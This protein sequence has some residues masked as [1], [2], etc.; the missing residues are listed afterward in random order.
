MSIPN[1]TAEQL[2]DRHGILRASADYF[3]Y[4]GYRYSNLKDAVAHADRVAL[5]GPL[6]Q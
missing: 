2:M 5:R 3:L 4:R 6:D 1:E